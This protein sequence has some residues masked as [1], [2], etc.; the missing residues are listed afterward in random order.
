MSLQSIRIGK[1]FIDVRFPDDLNEI[2]YVSVSFRVISTL[3]K[4]QGL[5]LRALNKASKFSFCGGK[6]IFPFNT[7]F[8]TDDPDID[9]A[10]IYFLEIGCDR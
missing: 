6:A 7:I 3:N 9:I 10:V 5:F 4:Y 2:L 8:F 1:P